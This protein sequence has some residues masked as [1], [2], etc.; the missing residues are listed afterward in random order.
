[1]S[2]VKRDR[3]RFSSKPGTCPYLTPEPKVDPLVVNS[4]S[5]Q[6]PGVLHIPDRCLAPTKRGTIVLFI[7]Q[8]AERGI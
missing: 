7:F 8:V 1:M 4:P 6:S 3:C 5:N 2:F